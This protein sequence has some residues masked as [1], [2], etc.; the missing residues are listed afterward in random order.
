MRLP[1]VL[2]CLCVSLLAACSG[3][4]FSGGSKIAEAQGGSI[5]GDESTISNSDAT[6][7]NGLP[8]AEPAPLPSPEAVAKL[9]ERC[10]KAAASS[11]KLV[12]QS[13]S[14][15]ERKTCSFGTSPNLERKDK[16]VQASETT[17]ASLNLPIG[18]ICNISIDSPADAK[19]HY[20]DFLIL[21]IDSRIVFMSNQGLNR[22]LAPPEQGILTWDFSKVV[23]QKIDNFEAAPY[24]LGKGADCILPGHDK[25][26]PVA[27][28]LTPQEIAP[29]A[30]AISGKSSASINLTATGDDNDTDCWHTALDV[31][32]KIQYLANP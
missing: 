15:P 18:D 8:A 1:G 17:P 5:T 7:G 2:L 31:K 10:E 25:E 28:H 29:I 23:G 22:Y 21:S 3:G 32:V 9:R 6:A 30:V 19:L 4:N 24:C 20:D 26:G 14:F 27:L 13:I 16:F 11:M 12:E